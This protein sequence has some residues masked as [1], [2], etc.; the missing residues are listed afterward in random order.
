MITLILAVGVTYG[1]TFT[2]YQPKIDSYQEQI[3]DLESK[4]TIADNNI[5]SLND[6]KAMLE[7]QKER[8][9]KLN[10]DLKDELDALETLYLDIKNDTLTAFDRLKV[11][12]L[13]LEKRLNQHI[14]ITHN[15]EDEAILWLDIRSA[16]ADVDSNLIPMIDTLIDDYRNLYVW[17]DNLPDGEISEKEAAVLM[18]DAYQILWKILQEDLRTFDAQWIKIINTDITELEMKLVV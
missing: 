10:N 2:F 17:I 3:T 8:Q 1:L 12:Q 16:A 5:D 9:I 18:Y 7:N 4:L 15:F 13:F 11:D 6:W 14:V